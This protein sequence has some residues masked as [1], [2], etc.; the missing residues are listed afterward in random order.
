V[1]LIGSAA[2]SALGVPLPREPGDLDFIATLDQY[3]AYA[4]RAREGDDLVTARPLSADKFLV[5]LRSDPR[6]R[7]LEIAWPGTTGEELLELARR[8]SAVAFEGHGDL[9]VARPQTVY[10]LKLSHRYLR[11]SP[12]FR[13]TMA[14]IKLLR[15]R[16]HGVVTAELRDWFR[17]REEETYAYGHPN[18]SQGKSGFFSGDG[19]EYVWDHDSLHEAVKL[20]PVPAYTLFK[21]DGAEVRVARAKFEALPGPVKLNSVLEEAYVLA[22]ERSQVP[23]NFEPSPRESFT[24]ALEKVC[25]SITSGWWREW[26]WEHHD[27]ALAVFDPG[28]VELF[29]RAVADGTVRRHG[30]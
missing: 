3:N 14:D 2:L 23:F 16:G 13:K 11:N 27:E 9:L 30:A 29:H 28:Y 8:N 7:E 15:A 10:A 20:G 26:A 25:T 1:L 24:I 4:R 18:L 19:I 21:E 12:H 22:L 6:P 5:K 17:R